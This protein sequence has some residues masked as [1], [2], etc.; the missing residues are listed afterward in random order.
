M[1]N[2]LKKAYRNL[3]S[4]IG[5]PYLEKIFAEGFPEHLKAPFVFLLTQEKEST[6]QEVITKIESIRNEMAEKSD[7]YFKRASFRFLNQP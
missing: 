2:I 3:L 6:T 7:I 5:S 4:Q 1:L